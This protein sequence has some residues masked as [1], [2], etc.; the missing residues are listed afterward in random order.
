MRET[1]QEQDVGDPQILCLG[2]GAIMKRKGT[3]RRGQQETVRWT[4]ENQR[5][6]W[7]QCLRVVLVVP[8]RIETAE[9]T[10][11]LGGRCVQLY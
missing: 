7:N 11:I 5:Y 9:A 10:V 2:R 6:W 8:T 4:R 1:H 3:I